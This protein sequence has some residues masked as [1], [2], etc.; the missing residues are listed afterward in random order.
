MKPSTATNPAAAA[1]QGATF[2]TAALAVTC[3]GALDVVE[4]LGV[5]GL[6]V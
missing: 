2:S 1:L 6:G 5:T 4:T 3:N